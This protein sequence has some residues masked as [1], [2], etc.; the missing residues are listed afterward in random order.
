MGGLR[1]KRTL[2]LWP[3]VD[4]VAETIVPT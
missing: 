3:L 2:L 1:E 4:R